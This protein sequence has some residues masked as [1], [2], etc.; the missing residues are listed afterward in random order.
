MQVFRQVLQL[1]P[2]HVQPLERGHSHHAV[3]H[4]AELVHGQIQ[5]LQVLQV[6]Q[7]TSSTADIRSERGTCSPAGLL[8]GP[9][10]APGSGSWPAPV[11]PGSGSSSVPQEPAESCCSSAGALLA[12]SAVLE[13]EVQRFSQHLW[14]RRSPSQLTNLLGD[15]LNPIAGKIQNQEVLKRGDESRDPLEAS[16]VN[17]PLLDMMKLDQTVRQRLLGT[18]GRSDPTR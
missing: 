5:V 16:S 18:R 12:D 14:R 1:I 3:W 2:P 11:S 17:L 6:P 9:G 13:A 7:L 4:L 10:A 8:P 15:L